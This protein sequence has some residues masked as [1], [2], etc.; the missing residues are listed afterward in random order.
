MMKDGKLAYACPKLEVWASEDDVVTTS[1]G[2]ED[3]YDDTGS[4]KESWFGG[5]GN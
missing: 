1:V 4:W 2:W 5:S 3:R